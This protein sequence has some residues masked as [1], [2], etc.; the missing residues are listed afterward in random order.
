MLLLCM[1]TPRLLLVV[2]ESHRADFRV[3][4]YA[5]KLGRLAFQPFLDLFWGD[6]FVFGE[7]YDCATPSWA[8]AQSQNSRP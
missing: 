6:S 8:P 1:N 3:T 7:I 5:P 4:D 2:V